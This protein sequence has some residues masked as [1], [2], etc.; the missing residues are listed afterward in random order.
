[1]SHVKEIFFKYYSNCDMEKVKVKRMGGY[2][3]KNYKISMEDGS[4]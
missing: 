3:T 4:E 1:M 2:V